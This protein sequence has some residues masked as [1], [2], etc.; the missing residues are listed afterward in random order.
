MRPDRRA[1][2]VNFNVQHQMML[3]L[4]RDLALDE[5]ES[6]LPVFTSIALMRVG[7]VSVAAV[8][9]SCVAVRLDLVGIRAREARGTFVKLWK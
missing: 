1:L 9:I 2:Q 5:S 7:I 4:S 3:R 6:L 8:R